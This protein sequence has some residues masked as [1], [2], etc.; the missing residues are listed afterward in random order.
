MENE[1]DFLPADTH[2]VFYKL[3]VSLWVWVARHVQS[4]QSNKFTRSLQY[5][6]ENLKDEVD[7]LPADIHLRFLQRDTL[8]L[9]ACHQ[10]YANYSK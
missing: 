5:L 8:I 10:A 7:F 2:K 6:K 4:T 3:I 9:G 1:F